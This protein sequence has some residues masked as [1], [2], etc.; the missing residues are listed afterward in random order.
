MPEGDT[1]YR[2][3]HTLHTALAGRSVTR[4]ATV[5]PQLARIDEDA[6]IAGRTVERVSSTGKN[7]VIEFSGDLFLRTHMR[8][9]GSWHIYKPGERWQRPR[10]AM[11]IVIETDAWVAVAFDVPVAELHDARSLER[12]DDLRNIGPDFLAE[13]FDEA[14]ALRRIR[15]RGDQS[16][17]DTL[18]NQRV[19]SGVG[20]EYK[21][22]VLFLARVSPFAAVSALDD[23][24]LRRILHLAR[25]L[26][27]AN[28]AKSSP[29]RVT[30]FSLDPRQTK[31]VYGRAG[32][33]CR[34]CGTAIE[35][36]RQ[37]P[38]ARVTFWCPGCQG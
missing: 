29:S 32:K 22:E 19:V 16:I 18:L 12:Q 15:E 38:D 7:L 3:A 11:R 10:D 24:T 36:A 28:V 2:A 21:S 4:F 6:P 17:A 20:N 33:P 37:G 14:E 30:T 31:Y 13:T 8:M 5:L 25:K 27:L 1:I 23:E 35:M 26:M 9:H 34:K